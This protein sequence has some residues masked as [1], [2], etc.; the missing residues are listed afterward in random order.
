MKSLRQQRIERD[1]A[2]LHPS[3]VKHPKSGDGYAYFN[4]VGGPH[5]GMRVRMYTPFDELV[6]HEPDVTYEL[7]APLGQSD[8]WV[9]VANQTVSNRKNQEVEDGQ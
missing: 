3:Q 6:F 8:E 9:Y 7:H 2:P 1:L 5:H 4:L